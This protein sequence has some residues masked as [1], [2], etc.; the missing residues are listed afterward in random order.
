MIDCI[1]LSNT[2]SEE[3]QTMT[4]EAI[5]SIRDSHDVNMFVVESNFNRQGESWYSHYDGEEIHPFE[6]FGYNKYLQLGLRYSKA[7]YILIVNNDIRMDRNCL[8]RL[9]K[10]LEKWDSV[11]PKDPTLN[12]H[13]NH[14]GEI[15]GY[16][17]SY[18]VCGWALM[19]KR[20][21]L[22]KITAEHLFPDALKFW[23]QDNFYAWQL[24]RHGFHHAM[25]SDAYCIHLG[26][27]SHELI[28][29]TYTNGQK[30]IYERLVWQYAQGS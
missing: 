15:E 6:P 16:R 28:D 7:P 27:K 8:P 9:L 20:E 3:I 19:F 2:Y 12:L 25:I 30:E 24:E 5:Q 11:S 22:E 10:A 21:V 26:S 14:R 18:Y 13:D 1:M 17:T 4:Q 29:E 23:Y